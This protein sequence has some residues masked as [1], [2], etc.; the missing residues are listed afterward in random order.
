MSE[1]INYNLPHSIFNS[2]AGLSKDNVDEVCAFISNL[3]IDETNSNGLSLYD[4][5]LHELLTRTGFES[6]LVAGIKKEIPFETLS[7]IYVSVFLRNEIISCN[8]FLELLAVIRSSS[9]YNIKRFNHRYLEF[10]GALYFLK[11]KRPSWSDFCSGFSFDNWHEFELLAS[12]LPVSNCQYSEFIQW[13]TRAVDVYGED[14]A[15]HR[16]VFHVTQ[17]IQ[18]DSA[19]STDFLSNLH[20]I[21][22]DPKVQIILP[23]VVFSLRKCF[24]SDYHFFYNK[25]KSEI[26]VANAYPIYFSIGNIIDSEKGKIEF[27]D[28]ILREFNSDNLLLKDLIRLCGHFVIYN[29]DIFTL[30]TKNALETEDIQ[31]ILAIVEMLQSWINK[32]PKS[33]IRDFGIVVFTKS[34]DVLKDPLDALLVNISKSDPET[35]FELL[36]IRHMIMADI[37]LLEMSISFMA[38]KDVDLFRKHILKCLNAEDIRLHR[39]LFGVSSITN[40]NSDVYKISTDFFVEYELS[41]RLYMAYKVVGFWY[42]MEPLQQ[43]IV[44]VI[45]SVSSPSKDL[46]EQFKF[47]L[48]EY[49]VYNYRSTLQILKAE[50][51][52]SSI[53]DFARTMFSDVIHEYDLYFNDLRSVEIDREI[54]PSKQNVRL[55]NFYL[56][57]SFSESTKKTR[58]HIFEF[59]KRVVINANNWA[60][61]RPNELKHVV[62]PL[63]TISAGGEF[64]SGEKLLPIYQEHL[65]LTYRKISKSEISIN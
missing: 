61:R 57:R 50:L 15:F 19:I 53:G 63:S 35:A 51:Q 9:V 48:S 5:E 54:R 65:R 29:Y 27:F 44:S 12:I 58:E 16:I 31:L 30:V 46:Q 55:H 62:T 43:L 37:N 40:I 33:W 13:I 47:I 8:T 1:I 34:Q 23:G 20:N 56:Q 17:W 6:Y 28:L 59:G 7:N 3:L 14:L 26:N 11:N 52:D 38:Q 49:L 39:S 4:D 60:I 64:P 45:K 10:S 25:L 36:E 21:A 42:S 18:R 2:G 24:D 22:N 41:S 32:V